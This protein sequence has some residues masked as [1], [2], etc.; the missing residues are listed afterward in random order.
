MDIDTLAPIV[1]TSRALLC[2]VFLI[3]AIGKLRDPTAFH[4]AVSAYRL[5][6]SALVAPAAV[7]IPWV[8]IVIGLSMPSG[9]RTA[10]VAACAM[11]GMFAA[12]MGINMS[13]GRRSIDCGCFRARPMRRLTWGTVARTVL[14]A[15]V[16]AFSGCPAAISSSAALEGLLAGAILFTLFMT[17]ASLP[18]LERKRPRISL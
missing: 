3:S 17:A 1:V 18:T 8:E 11:L 6:P 13:R 2:L 5:L 10:A 9:S 15:G 7:M 4:G 16:A 12:A 14:L